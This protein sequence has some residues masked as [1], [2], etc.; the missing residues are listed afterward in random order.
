MSRRRLKT[1]LWD[2]N[3]EIWERLPRRV[4][5]LRAVR[6]YGVWLHGFVSRHADRHMPFGTLFL[7][8]RPAL[9]LMRRLADETPRNSTL[10]IAVLGCSIGAEVYS[11]LWTLRRARPDLRIVMRAVDID[12]G[13]LQFAEA[14][15]YGP[16]ASEMVD[17]SIFQRLTPHEMHDMFDWEGDIG[18]VK[19]WLREDITWQVGDASDPNLVGMVGLQDIVVASNFLCHM[20][21]PDAE[22]CLRN[23]AALVNGG[24]Y[25]F[26]SGVDL[27][28]RTRVAL[29]LQWKPVTELIAEIHD[30]DPLVRDD[31]PWQW[32][33]L[34]PLDRGKPGWKIR[35]A[36]AFRLASR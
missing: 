18:R 13:V 21:P 11:I 34:E 8:N 19:P 24:G 25:V 36:S 35:Y 15:T 12:P 26:V 33:G 14:G 5:E 17:S 2:L 3:K 31:W 32:W 6:A 10:R 23:F 20:D 4:R 7:R 1:A 22:R 28:V 9:E 30:G 16:E 29:D 27:D